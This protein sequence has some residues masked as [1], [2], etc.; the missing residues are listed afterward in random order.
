MF[1]IKQIHIVRSNVAERLFKN[2]LTEETCTN[3]AVFIICTKGK[4]L[5]IVKMKLVLVKHWIANQ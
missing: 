3:V 1:R 2:V 4:L 5:F